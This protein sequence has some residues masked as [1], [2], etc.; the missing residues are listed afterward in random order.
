MHCFCGKLSELE[1]QLEYWMSVQ[2]MEDEN[3][4]EFYV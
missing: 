4:D 1:Q 2:A 3:L